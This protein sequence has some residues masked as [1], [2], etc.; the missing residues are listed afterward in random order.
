MS[1]INFLKGQLD[2]LIKFLFE[3]QVEDQKELIKQIK[4]VRQMLNLEEQILFN[5]VL[6]KFR[7]QLPHIF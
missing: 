2:Y 7:E 4:Y 1:T 5:S 3:C 6:C